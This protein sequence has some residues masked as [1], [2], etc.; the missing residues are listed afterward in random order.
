MSIIT[1]KTLFHFT[2][3]DALINIL[4]T[5]FRPTYCTEFGLENME[6]ALKEMMIPMVCF[7]DLPLSKLD[8]HINGYSWEYNGT[9]HQ[10]KQYGSYGL[11]MS[12]EWGIRRRLNPVTYVNPGSFLLEFA[13]NSANELNRLYNEYEDRWE[14][15]P[16][17]EHIKN[18]Y[19]Y[20]LARGISMGV[21]PMPHNYQTFFK[22]QVALLNSL[23]TLGYMKP[24]QNATTGQVYYDEREWRVTVPHTRRYMGG[25]PSL[26]KMGD[27]FVP[28]IGHKEGKVYDIDEFKKNIADY[29]MFEFNADDIKYIIVKDDSDIEDV[30]K[31]LHELPNKYSSE[32]IHLLTT[33]IL[34]CKQLREDF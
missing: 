31:R 13:G 12:K 24:Y 15:D 10:S 5:G 2:Q 8:K 9:T 34:T 17:D 28:L 22:L 23:A 33:R 30:I 18:Y 4:G 27:Q 16:T 1:A 32:A 26:V 25:V 19:N 11:G 14:K 29:Y 3:K 20:P 7:C 21:P 6:D